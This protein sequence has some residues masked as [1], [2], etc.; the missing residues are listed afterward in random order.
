M[1]LRQRVLSASQVGTFRRC[2]LQW[3]LR[4]QC[5][6]RMKPPA[7]LLKGR[8]VHTAV[9][10]GYRAKIESG[11][12]MPALDLMTDA[13]SAEWDKAAPFT[14]FEPDEQ[15]GDL[16]DR[17]V[18]LTAMHHRTI[19]PHVE[20]VLVEE[21]LRY[22]LGGVA[23][24]G[25][26]DC[27]SA[28]GTV[29]DVK[30]AGR[31]PDEN[32]L[33]VDFQLA[34]YCAGVEAQGIPVRKIALDH[35]V[36]L[37]TPVVEITELERADVDVARAASVAQTVAHQMATQQIVPTDDPRTC[38]YCEFK[39]MCWGKRWERYV[40]EPTSAIEAARQ[41]MPEQLLPADAPR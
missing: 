18:R 5:G 30:V 6:V 14:A 32:G 24:L 4:Y 29:R 35:L 19:M 8:A 34:G 7:V 37:K 11:G 20:P 23:M 17:T 21:E 36:D 38:S 12:A 1:T 3:H 26:I 39:A 16:K 31:R 22:T 13:A 25:Y 41:T 40:A 2:S 33:A 9:A 15:P 10:A 28:D 27:L